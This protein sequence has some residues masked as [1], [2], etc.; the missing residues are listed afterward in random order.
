MG[1]FWKV[2]LPA[3][4]A[5]CTVLPLDLQKDGQPQHVYFDSTEGEGES[6]DDSHPESDGSE[7]ASEDSQMNGEEAASE[8]EPMTD[9]DGH[10]P[11][12]AG[13][14]LI[15]RATSIEGA[16][17]DSSSQQVSLEACL[18]QAWVVACSCAVCCTRAWMVTELAPAAGV[19]A[20]SC[21]VCRSYA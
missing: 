5:V 19:Q 10:T 4:S 16:G 15:E 1:S 13:M 20:V 12:A 18:L 8:D 14:D 7:A 11:L 9:A 6:S 21:A 2:D 3:V 17:A